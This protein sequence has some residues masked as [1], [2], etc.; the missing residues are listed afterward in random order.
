MR[1][2]E[3]LVSVRARARIQSTHAAVSGPYAATATP[4]DLV[5]QQ[6]SNNGSI[7]VIIRTNNMQQQNDYSGGDGGGG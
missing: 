6:S 3:Y 2:M 5:K 7:I 4:S 1:D